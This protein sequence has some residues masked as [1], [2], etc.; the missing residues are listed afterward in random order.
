MN[1]KFLYFLVSLIFAS[2][3]AQTIFAQDESESKKAYEF[4][5]IKEVPATSVKNQYRSGTCWSFSSL[6]FVESELLRLGK[7]EYDLSDMF[8]VKKTYEEKAIK[9]IRFQGALNFSGGG[10]FHDVFHVIKEYGI[11]PEEVYDGKVIGEENHIHGELDAVTKAYV[12]AVLKNKNKKLTPV[13][14]KGFQG[15]TDAYLGEIPE[16][17]TYNEKEYTPQSFA[18]ELDLKVEDYIEIGSIC[19]F[20]YFIYYR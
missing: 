1:N 4:T 11:V 10:A 5:I 13:W 3:F 17:F 2:F 16:S 8:V 19:K 14:F 18:A 12:E 6:A 20:I 7:G 9:Y 15:I